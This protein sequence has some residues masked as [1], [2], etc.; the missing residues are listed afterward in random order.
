M[1]SIQV[2]LINIGSNSNEKNGIAPIHQDGTF[3][4][5]PIAE[6]RPGP[7]T[8]RFKDLGLTCPHP[9]LRA[10]YDPRF[11]PTP[12]YGDVRDRPAFRSLAESLQSSTKPLLLFAATLRYTDKPFMRP[13]G[14]YIIGYFIVE[15]I[16]FASPGG[17]LDWHGHQ[18]NAH[19]L[20]PG[21]DRGRVRVLVGG[22]AGSRLLRRPFTI[23]VRPKSHLEPSAWLRQNFRE[24]RGGPI[25]GGPWCRRTFRNAQGTTVKSILKAISKKGGVQT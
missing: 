10:H 11:E 15:E 5:W 18:H 16:R 17:D 2:L 19:Y 22:A 24:L 9:D 20:R 3:E 7:R 12:T 6:E 21:H 8:P 25:G 23:S 13:S 14:Y 4:Y 1:P